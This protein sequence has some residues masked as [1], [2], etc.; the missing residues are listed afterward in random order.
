M[1]LPGT[2]GMRGYMVVRLRPCIRSSTYLLSSTP[3]PPGGIM[4]IS[5]FEIILITRVYCVE[6][7]VVTGRCNPLLPPPACGFMSVWVHS[8]LLP[9][10]RGKCYQVYSYSR[11]FGQKYAN[12]LDDKMPDDAHWPGSPTLV[13]SH[14]PEYATL[15]WP[16]CI[17][18]RQNTRLSLA[19][20]FVI[21][22]G[23]G[24]S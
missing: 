2:V 16:E 6:L 9:P 8:A 15:H 18:H 20:P 10:T 3:P 1:L 11:N 23:D 21:T 4:Q 5:N 19:R 13:G 7:A 24:G 17:G 14:R 12:T 22:D